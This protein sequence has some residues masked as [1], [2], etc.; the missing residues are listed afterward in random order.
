MAE[1]HMRSARHARPQSRDPEEIRGMHVARNNAPAGR[2]FGPVPEDETANLHRVRPAAVRTSAPVFPARMSV[3]PSDAGAA[4]LVLPSLA[5]A[6][7]ALEHDRSRARITNILRS[8][9]FI[10]VVA[11][12]AAVLVAVLLL[13]I[14]RIYGTSMHGTLDAG[15]V[16]VSA[17]TSS[18]APGDV[19]AFYYNNNI[20]V[21]RVIANSGD[22]VD[23]DKDGNVYV[24]N[25]QLD[26]PYLSSK[27]YGETNITLPYQVPD[28]K[29]FVMGDNRE[30]SIDSRNTSVGCVSS[31]QVVGKIVFRLWPLTEIGPVG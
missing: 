27:A 29:V 19:V 6:Q 1:K 14:L 7:E 22:W 11:A 10:L 2:H 20:L 8:T 15:D 16:V 23:I 5:D 30:V 18:M 31:E 13:P 21:K 4:A 3:A 17:K 12:A 25:Q 24:N 26:E 28:G 9:A